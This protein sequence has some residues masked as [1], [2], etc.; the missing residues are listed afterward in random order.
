MSMSKIYEW[1]NHE[2]SRYYKITV[3]KQDYDH[4]V[5]NY[6]W[7]S[8]N[9]NRGGTKNLLVHTDEEA[10]KHVIKMLKRRKSRGYELIS[11]LS[12]SPCIN[13]TKSRTGRGRKNSQC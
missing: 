7:G 9:S 10:E 4:I 3:H 1:L 13:T 11:P 2:K 12:G 8:C 6:D 5:L